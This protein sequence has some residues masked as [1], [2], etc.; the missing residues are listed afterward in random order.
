MLS[1]RAAVGDEMVTQEQADET[2]KL[3]GDIHRRKKIE[4]MAEAIVDIP[5]V[6]RVESRLGVAP[7][8][9][10]NVPSVRLCF[11]IAVEAITAWE[12]AKTPPKG[13][14]E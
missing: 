1:A 3:I 4:M 14:R 6:R 2:G 9:L 8:C 11:A 13:D 12:A 5:F 7:N 10:G